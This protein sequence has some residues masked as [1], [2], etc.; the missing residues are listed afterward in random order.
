MP[1]LGPNRLLNNI[2]VPGLPRPSPLAGNLYPS[3]LRK[4]FIHPRHQV[5][6]EEIDRE[7][8][9][10]DVR[11]GEDLALIAAL[12]VKKQANDEDKDEVWS[13]LN[14]LTTFGLVGFGF[15]YLPLGNRN[16]Q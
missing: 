12:A 10:Q 7:L 5:A 14:E 3:F 13:R 6:T 15:F 16:I 1:F 9:S 2:A 8:I 11:G 4:R